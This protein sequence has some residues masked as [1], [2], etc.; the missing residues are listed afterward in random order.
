MSFAAQPAAAPLLAGVG[1]LTAGGFS[2]PPYADLRPAGPAAA[3]A[4]IM[5]A[6]CALAGAVLGLVFRWYARRLTLVSVGMYTRMRVAKR[7]A[8]GAHGVAAG[9][10]AAPGGGTGG[11]TAGPGGAIDIRRQLAGVILGVAA[12]PPITAVL[13]ASRAHLNLA[14]VAWCT[15]SRW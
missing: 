14:D 8:G 1:W 2:R 3:Y 15:W 5:L 12:L 4:A 11:G 9:G 6:A 7:A 10:P 13:A